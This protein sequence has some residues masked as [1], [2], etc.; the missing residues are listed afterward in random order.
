MDDPVSAAK[1]EFQRAMEK[2]ES[3][4]R[5]GLAHGFFELSVTC[6]VIKEGRRRLTIRSGRSF[7]FIIP[8]E[9]TTQKIA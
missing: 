3:E 4:V 6:E 2:L 7:Q 8:E 5:K 9:V 1:Q